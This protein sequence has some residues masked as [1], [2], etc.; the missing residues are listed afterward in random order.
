VSRTTAEPQ[1]LQRAL[2][3]QAQGRFDEAIDICRAIL[4]ASPQAFDAWHLL[5]FVQAAR[6]RHAEALDALD[7]ALSLRPSDP[8]VHYNRAVSLQA[9]RRWSDA[10]TSYDLALSVRPAFPDALNNRGNALRAQRKLLDALA[11]FDA[12]LA[13]R[14]NHFEALSNR[15]MALQELGRFEDA[16]AAYDM[17][18][19][20]MPDHADAHHQRGHVL[21][22][23]R[24][25]DAALA[26]YDAALALR[27]QS[28]DVLS[29][30]SITLRELNRPAD[31][32]T[33]CEAALAVH[34]Q[35]FDAL[36][37][38]GIALQALSRREEALE[39]F[40]AALA[41][42][43]D[44]PG[45]L[46]NR[47]NVLQQ[48]NRFDEA[49]QSYDAALSVQPAYVEALTNRA[50][51]LQHLRRLDE[52]LTNYAAALS[53]RPAY[54]EARFAESL[55]RL[56][57][58]DFEHGWQ[59]YES[60]WE[61]ALQRGSKRAFSQPRWN[62]QD[63]IADRTLLIHA[64]QGHGDTIQFCRYVPLLAEKGAKVVLEVQ[65]A[66]KRLLQGLAGAQSIVARG[67]PLPR[68]DCHCPLLSLPRAFD[69]TLATIPAPPRLRVPEQL[70]QTWSARLPARQGMR[71]GIVWAGAA[72]FTDDRNRSA[73]LEPML[74]LKSLPIE[75]VAL[76][77][78]LGDGDEAMLDA[79][80]I[81]H[82]GPELTDFLE[83]AALA[84]A[85]DLVISVDTS[86]AHLAATLEV[87]TWLLLPF[88]ADWRWLLDRDDSPW[89]PSVRMFRQ[90]TAGD[91]PSVTAA[92]RAEL[93]ARVAS[94]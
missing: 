73:G 6:G 16:V 46:N 53:L 4:N 22:Q 55:C 24:H 93:E 20:L 86:V 42:R 14:P 77:K 23:L 29:D 72:G 56:R 74:A 7:K 65:P 33:S 30:R 11:S 85:M 31:A 12:A 75:L 70:V 81:M 3:A 19:A 69:T 45:A 82:F 44:H 26:S 8:M 21:H 2:A 18:I 60:R 62:A 78:E 68:F 87:E 79:H 28:A 91:W 13:L 58:G 47:A 57:M 67:D 64:E 66:L 36:N 41:L 10:V 9:L 84:S 39:S 51:T 88:T 32:L 25:F 37:N 63:D 94:G 5:G 80:D 61:T 54:A 34:P 1:L 27:P 52:A 17:V 76:Q 15:A 40:A 38:R 50:N 35:H 48:L 89:Y 59:G 43:P 90:P 83:T 92:V 71:I 49:L